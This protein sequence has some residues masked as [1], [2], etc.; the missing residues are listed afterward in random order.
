[1][2]W[3]GL[4]LRNADGLVSQASQLLWK[5]V[6]LVEGSDGRFLDGS[7]YLLGLAV[8]PRT[9][10]FRQSTFDAMLET[11]AIEDIWSEEAPGWSLAV[12]GRIDQTRPSSPCS[13][14]LVD[15]QVRTGLLRDQQ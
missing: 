13:S 1:M 14:R 4:I 9:I 15:G 10:R 8:G 12:P 2:R 5:D 7:V 11:N 3:C 6:F